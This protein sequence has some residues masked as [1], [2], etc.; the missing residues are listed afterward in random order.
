MAKCY[1]Q[2]G[3]TGDLINALGFLWKEAQSGEKPKLI[4]SAEFAPLLDGVSYVE[5]IIYN[6]P[7]YEIE[8]AIKTVGEVG[9][10]VCSIQVNGPIEQVRD[11]SYRPAGTEHATTTS[12]QKEGWRL[13]G[14]LK[15]WDA[16]AHKI[17]FDRRDSQREEALLSRVLP[18]KGGRPRK[19]ILVS[20][21]SASS[22][23]P[24][25]DLLWTLLRLK[26]CQGY[27]LVDL[28][29]VKAERFYDLLALYEKAAFL[30][31]VDS[32]PLQLA[33][34]VPQ[35]PVI[36]LTQ[37]KP[38][39]W[40]GSSWQPNWVWC[41]R[42]S[43]FPERAHLMLETETDFTGGGLVAHPGMFGRDASML[44]D[45]KRIPFLRDYIRA[46]L[47]RNQ[48]RISIV[49]PGVQHAELFP[50]EPGAAVYAYRIEGGQFS[51]VGDLFS[52]PREFWKGILPEIPDL[53]L[54]ADHYWSECLIHIFRRHG[55][56]DITG[57]CERIAPVQP[58]A[59]SAPNT[60]PPRLKRNRELYISLRNS[61][62][63]QPRY[64]RVADQVQ[65]IPIRG[66]KHP[67]GY[68]PAITQFGGLLYV[69]YRHHNGSSATQIS[70]A[71]LNPDFTSRG[72]AVMPTAAR[73]TEDARWFVHQGELHLAW[74]ESQWPEKAVSV[75][76][77]GR[78]GAPAGLAVQPQFCVGNDGSAM[79]KNWVLWE[80]GERLYCL[81]RCS[82]VHEVFE[83]RDYQYQ[84]RIPTP[85]PVWAYGEIRGG[86]PPLPYE[87]KWLR[88]FHS[89]L[90]NEVFGPR[91]RYYVGALL[92][93]PKPPFTV[94]AV[95]KR[96]ILYGSEIDLLSPP[97]RTRCHH[98]K[99]NVVFPAGAIE[100]NGGWIVSI[101]VNDSACC[102]AK[103]TPSDLH[104]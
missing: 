90:R 87:G 35:L 50:N 26:F 20:A 100:H 34:A 23:F 14:H 78:Y 98:W 73:S 46:C 65:T 49:R 57:F 72:E 12:F 3:K 61:L 84:G 38:A 15:D 97:E 74:V 45:V 62:G 51:P 41:C 30:V 81:Y 43:D 53:L 1:L 22:P 37:D 79:Q 7:H 68:N 82:P 9:G 54:G 8:K 77:C 13:A 95:S 71:V 11:Y 59:A 93:E 69:A 18:K 29:D 96:P 52:A 2:L 58:A 101:G 102:L 56:R 25:K 44:G 19:L 86:T 31:A 36:A 4:V 67:L 24:Y 63:G 80:C 28:A 6:G 48:E 83:L 5:S 64:P 42:Y 89:S 32:A 33:R 88:F 76:K 75:V 103:L 47:R 55:A 17:V 85:G 94:L 21:H 27:Q 70:V 60:E 91:W 104:L 39:L 99:G 16:L 40:N 10:C 66:L 92:V